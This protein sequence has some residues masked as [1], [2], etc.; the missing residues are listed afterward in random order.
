MDC[1]SIYHKFT[2]IK[3]TKLVDDTGEIQKTK[4]QKAH[5]ISPKI[6]VIFINT[7][8]VQGTSVSRLKFNERDREKNP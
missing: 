5:L 7:N 4:R 2:K 1:P 6:R 3:H 8:F